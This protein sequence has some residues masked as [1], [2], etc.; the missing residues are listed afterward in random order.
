MTVCNRVPSFVYRTDMRFKNGKKTFDGVL[1]VRVGKTEPELYAALK[2]LIENGAEKSWLVK[3]S[4]RISLPELR[5]EHEKRVDRAA[6]ALHGSSLPSIPEDSKNR[7]EMKEKAYAAQLR[8]ESE[9]GHA[10]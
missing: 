6:V 2:E 7:K 5:R 1:N 9:K 3:E 10:S 8:K 4:L